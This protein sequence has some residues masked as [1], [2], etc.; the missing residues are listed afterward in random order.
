MMNTFGEQIGKPEKE[1]VRGRRR[2]K[3]ASAHA[4]LFI[5]ALQLGHSRDA[6]FPR[7]EESHNEAGPSLIGPFRP[8]KNEVLLVESRSRAMA[9]KSSQSCL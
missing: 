8:I 4:S 3:G 6:I 2:E 1:R 9:R 5:R 7:T